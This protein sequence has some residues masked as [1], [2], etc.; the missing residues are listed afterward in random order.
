MK[1]LGPKNPAT[2]NLQVEIENTPSVTIDDG[3]V[4]GTTADGDAFTDKPVVT[5][6]VYAADPTASTLTDGDAGNILLN[7]QR[8]QVVADRVYDAVSDANKSI[9][10]FIPQDRYS[11]ADLSGSQ[12]DSDATISY[13]ASMENSS[14]YSLQYI[15]SGDGYAA[16]TIHGSNEDVADITTSTFTPITEDHFGST[17]FNTEKWLEKDTTTSMKSMRIDIEVTGLS[18]GDTSLWS[19]YMLKKSA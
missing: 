15:P 13:Y 6:G 19:L 9:P 16:L 14:F 17:S 3:Y 2:Q 4:Q 1:T 10:V 12:A 11:F 7:E 18:G 5:G 8:M